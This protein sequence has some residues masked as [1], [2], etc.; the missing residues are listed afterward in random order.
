MSLFSEFRPYTG[1]RHQSTDPMYKVWT[2]E[3]RAAAAEARHQSVDNKRP[4]RVENP[5]TKGSETTQTR[6]AASQAKVNAADQQYKDKY[7][8]TK[9][10]KESYK[11][12]HAANV[13]HRLEAHSAMQEDQGYAHTKMENALEGRKGVVITGMLLKLI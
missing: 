3:S 2:D 1:L 6:M 13:N 5:E 8:Q 11:P 12:L 4:E 10:F 7:E 9:D